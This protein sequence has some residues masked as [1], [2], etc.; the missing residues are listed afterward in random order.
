MG[1]SRSRPPLP[2]FDTESNFNLGNEFLP[3]LTFAYSDYS[4]AKKFILQYNG[5]KGTFDS[6]RREL[7]RLI[8]W[9]WQIASKS[10]TCLTRQDIERYISFCQRPPKKWIGIKNVSRF[11]NKDNK[12]I[13]NP[14]WRMFVAKVTK[15]ETKKGNTPNTNDYEFSQA[16]LLSLFAALGSFYNYLLHENKIGFNPIL[17]IRQKSKYLRKY[18]TKRTIRRLSDLQWNYV[19]TIARD[20]AAQDPVN[21]ERTLFIITSLYLMYLRISELVAKPKWIPQMGH[22]FLDSH[23]SWWFKTVSKGNKER[24][25]SVSDNMIIALKR[26]RKYLGLTPPLPLPN[27]Q[28]FLITSLRTNEPISSDRP[29]R[30]LVQICFDQALDKLKQNGF[31][32]EAASLEEATVHWLRH[33]GISDDINKHNR[34]ISHVRDDAG[35]SSSATTDKYNDI[36]LQDRNKSAKLKTI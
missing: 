14:H 1:T 20:M 13:P 36:D 19:I 29:L 2:L 12:R 23:G 24:D 21:H 30:K 34:P 22:F 16:A 18:Q 15:S 8:H 4:H 25:I 35:H 10:I 7:E 31:I 5:S 33:T 9:S 32:D 3:K 26:Y 11:I 17:Q 28:T 27:D 6:Y